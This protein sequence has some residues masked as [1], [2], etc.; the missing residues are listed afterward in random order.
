MLSTS[1]GTQS[2]GV[3]YVNSNST[4]QSSNSTSC[5]VDMGAGARPT[6][7]LTAGNTVIVSIAV[8]TTA[9][10]TVNV[11]DNRGSIYS[12]RRF[13]CNVAGVAVELWSAT[14]ATGSGTV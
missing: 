13:L 4:A 8:P 14:I 1:F 7:G 3:T 11:T 6:N 2:S 5:A 12:W 10:K 9:Y